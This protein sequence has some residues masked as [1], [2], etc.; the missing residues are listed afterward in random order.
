[1]PGDASAMDGEVRRLRRLHPWVKVGVLVWSGDAL[2]YDEEGREVRLDA[3][4]L[5]RAIVPRPSGVVVALRAT[6]I[7]R[8]PGPIT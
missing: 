4:S 7:V 2:G 1:M 3:D 8:E 6:T 5:V